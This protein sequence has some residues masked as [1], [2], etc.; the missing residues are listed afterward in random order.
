M[1]FFFLFN[2]GNLARTQ[3]VQFNVTRKEI[4]VKISLIIILKFVSIIYTNF[5]I[6]APVAHKE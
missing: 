5:K 4:E 3:R 2:V 6:S 1:F